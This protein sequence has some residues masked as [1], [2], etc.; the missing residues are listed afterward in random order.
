MAEWLEWNI[1]FEGQKL[2]EYVYQITVVTFAAIGFGVGFYL[3]SLEITLQIYAI[4]VVLSAL[5]VLPP[6]PFYNSHPVQWLAEKPIEE[7]TRSEKKP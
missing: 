1:D 6:W 3:Q 7:N 5:L 2:A 4:G